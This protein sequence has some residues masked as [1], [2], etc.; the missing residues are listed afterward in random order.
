MTK[1]LN[2]IGIAVKDMEKSKIK[3]INDGYEII[4]ESYEDYFRTQLCLMRKEN[5]TIELVYTNDRESKLYSLCNSQEEKNYHKCY[6]VNDL[7][8]EIKELRNQGYILVEDVVYSNL[9][10]SNVCFLY[11]K[12][13]GL[14][15]LLEV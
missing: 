10:S 11:N 14:I 7:I 9:F 3:Y 1:K 12:E 6:E 4:G 13:E 8:Y 5:E 15:E 2:H